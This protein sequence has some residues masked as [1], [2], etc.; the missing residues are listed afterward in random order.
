MIA[1]PG[2]SLSSS[3]TSSTCG[4]AGEKAYSEEFKAAPSRRNA[5]L[6]NRF[7]HAGVEHFIATGLVDALNGRALVRSAY[8]QPTRQRAAFG[9][10]FLMG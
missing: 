1:R 3:K 6:I 5:S 2:K 9:W 10:V 7:E 4:R 8:V